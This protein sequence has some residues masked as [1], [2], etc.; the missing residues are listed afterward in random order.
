MKEEF[1]YLIQ[2]DGVHTLWMYSSYKIDKAQLLLRC[3]HVKREFTGITI[4]RTPSQVCK[5]LLVQY[6]IDAITSG[7][8]LDFLDVFCL[9][10]HE[11]PL[12]NKRAALQC[13]R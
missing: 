13:Y 7:S 9:P 2:V 11:P 4:R 5:Q 12:K 3:F 8:M 6:N 10:L 1:V